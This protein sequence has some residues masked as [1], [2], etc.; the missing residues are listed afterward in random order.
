MRPDAGALAV[1]E[2]TD[3]P[4]LEAQRPAWEELWRTVPDATPFQSPAWLIPWWRHVGE[5]SL[6]TLAVRHHGALVGLFPFYRYTRP[7]TGERLL[8]PLGIATTDYLDALVRPGHAPQVLDIAARHLALRAGCDAWEWP[9][10]RQG[11]PLLAL[12]A[13]AGWAE[14]VGHADP[15]PC[16]AL[17]ETVDGLAQRVSAKTLRDLRTVRRRAEQAGALHWETEA[18]GIEEPFDALLRLHAARW[19]MRGEDGVLAAPGVQAMHREALPA[20]HRA[21]LLRFH[22]LRLDGEIVAALYGLADPPSRRARR[23]Y[24]YLSGFDPA[25]ERLSPGM[26]L[27][28]RAVEAAIAE[29][30]AVADFLRGQERYKYF[31]GAQDQ[32][33]FHRRLV[34][35]CAAS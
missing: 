10:L 32:P 2:V 6:L 11:S 3:R 24:F 5:G 8:F 30:L 9:Q 7:E 20:L 25:L 18:D 28:G 27:V 12:P 34:P 19:R 14:E 16:L 1:E 35:P 21:G 26:L 17:P 13:P 23:L 15:C 31:W 33:S 29:G 4:G 22:A